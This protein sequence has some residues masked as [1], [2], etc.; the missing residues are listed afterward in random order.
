MSPSQP[1]G[2][3]RVALVPGALIRLKALKPKPY[4]EHPQ[5]IGEHLKR[6]RLLRGLHQKDAAALL[7]VETS[8]LLKWEKGRTQPLVR[9]YP[10]IRSFLGY[11]PSPEPQTLPERMCAKRQQMGWTIRQAAEALGVDET[12]WGDWE[13][14]KPVKWPRSRRWLREFLA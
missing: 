4:P 9:Y 13:R 14:G 10:V 3:S 2:H 11:D 12:T 5:T 8:T 6:A 1:Q 7:G